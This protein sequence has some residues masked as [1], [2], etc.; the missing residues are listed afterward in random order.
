MSPRGE[1]RSSFAP[2]QRIYLPYAIGHTL[3]LQASRIASSSQTRRLQVPGQLMSEALLGGALPRHLDLLC[4]VRPRKDLGVQ[5][6]NRQ[7]TQVV[8]RPRKTC[9]RR[10][11]KPPSEVVEEQL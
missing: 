10:S 11:C 6:D 2:N 1:S 7:T 3:S 8:P 4:N 5:G 9:F